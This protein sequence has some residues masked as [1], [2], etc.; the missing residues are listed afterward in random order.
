MNPRIRVGSATG[1]AAMQA[2]LLIGPYD[3]EDMIVLEV[4]VSHRNAVAAFSRPLSYR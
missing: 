1:Q 4:I 2:V 3:S